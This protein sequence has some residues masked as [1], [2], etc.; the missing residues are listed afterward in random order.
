MPLF[1]FVSGYLSKYSSGNKAK[2]IQNL[3]LPYIIF[4]IA[5]IVL[6]SSK[7]SPIIEPQSVL[8]YLLALFVW[9]ISIEYLSKFRGLILFSIIFSVGTQFLSV[10]AQ[11][12]MRLVTFFPFFV[13]GYQ[14]NENYIN[15]IKKI[16]KA[17]SVLFIIVFFVITFILVQR[18]S[19]PYTISQYN[20]VIPVTSDGIKFFAFESIFCGIGIFISI[21]IMNLC[22]REASIF[23]QIGK[24]SLVIYLFHS[25]PFLREFM[26]NINPFE[27]NVFSF[28]YWVCLSLF[29]TWFLSREFIVKIYQRSIAK[30][31][32][33]ILKDK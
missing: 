5:F 33:Y 9:R 30:I 12:L 23:T 19:I 16:P 18:F 10:S 32:H 26:N 11:P 7:S 8:W 21:I 22:S 25:F 29:V 31:A 4:N 6:T 24:N 27:N 1:A 15:R 14:V 13:L 2:L 17:I 28:I 20:S 3:F